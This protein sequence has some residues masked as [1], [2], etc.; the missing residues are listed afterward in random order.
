M[1]N[2]K[3]SKLQIF[4]NGLIKENPVLVLVLGTC[5]TLAISTSVEA[6]FGMG[7]AATVVLICSNMAISAPAEDHPGLRP[8][9]LLHRPRGRLR[10]HRRDGLGS[11]RLQSL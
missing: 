3:I 6:A 1:S 10:H 11:L 4:L 8:Y 2:T 5:P 9:P 7:I